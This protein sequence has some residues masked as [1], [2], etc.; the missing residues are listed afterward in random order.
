MKLQETKETFVISHLR[1]LHDYIDQMDLILLELY[2]LWT[3]P[4]FE[5]R[6]L[7]ESEQ[8]EESSLIERFATTN[9]LA[10]KEIDFINRALPKS[11]FT[12]SQK[13]IFENVLL[14]VVKKYREYNKDYKD[15]VEIDTN[16]QLKL[17]HKDFLDNMNLLDNKF[18]QYNSYAENKILTIKKAN[19]ISRKKEIEDLQKEETN[20]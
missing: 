16:E 11:E 13:N 14:K 20:D 8:N 5:S 4:L 17:V 19:E 3:T 15:V 2:S 1:K 7:N 18:V 12:T 9:N 6:K 10:C